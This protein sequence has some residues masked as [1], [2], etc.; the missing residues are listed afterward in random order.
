MPIPVQRSHGW[1]GLCSALALVAGVPR[2]SD[3]AVPIAMGRSF[4]SAGIG[5]IMGAGPIYDSRH[6]IAPNQI[7]AQ[8][9]FH[10][11]PTVLGGAGL[12]FSS[13]NPS[14]LQ[15][16]NQTRYNITSTWIPKSSSIHALELSVMGS[17]NSISS[18]LDTVKG[19]EPLTDD[20][21]DFGLLARIAYGRRLS[22]R[23]GWWASAAG[24]LDFR[25]FGSNTGISPGLDAETG[26]TF[27]LRPFW[28]N[29][30][31]LSR[32]WDL[33]LRIPFQ[34]RAA[35]P[36]LTHDGARRGPAWTLGAQIG[37]SGL[38]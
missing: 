8:T 36:Y 5:M 31:N 23:F 7:I 28:H 4:D 26:L 30:D 1:I 22:E 25:P 20:G 15:A 2:T 19:A 10:Y 11:Y 14:R 6:G 34:I 3:G 16:F 24:A 21:V 32:S 27:N 18:Y 37:P 9:W 38:F 33:F 17:V 29:A 35:T 13:R 12:D